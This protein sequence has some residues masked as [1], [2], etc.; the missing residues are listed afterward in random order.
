MPPTMHDTTR[1]AAIAY[2]MLLSIHVEP[3][4]IEIGDEEPSITMA[5]PNTDDIT[6]HYCDDP[7]C[8]EC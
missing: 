4:V 2:L 6:V 5:D 7:N 1:E 3:T 8:T